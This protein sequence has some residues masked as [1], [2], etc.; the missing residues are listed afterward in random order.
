MSSLNPS[1][2]QNSQDESDITAIA[3]SPSGSRLAFF[4][5]ASS[6]LIHVVPEGTIDD[7]EPINEIKRISRA[8]DA[9]VHVAT[10]DSSSNFL[11]SGSA[12][13]VVKVW[14]VQRGYAT[15]LFKSHGGVISVLTF[16]HH[17][18]TTSLD[19]DLHLITGCVDCRIRLF[20]LTNESSRSSTSKP[21]AVLEGHTSVPKS[22]DI[23]SDGKWLIT[24]GRDG[25]AHLWNYPSSSSESKSI[26][27]APMK[28]IPLFERVEALAI[29]SSTNSAHSSEPNIQFYTGGEKGIVSVWDSKRAKWS[30]DLGQS[31]STKVKLS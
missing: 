17:K 18:A 20:R 13:G 12:D 1:C 26:T 5:S 6:L 19:F 3:V 7:K 28:T 25:V 24:G 30:N 11:A 10:F 14:D 21:V 2:S 15:H 9:P 8:H 4:T 23:S 27:Q 22:I 29:I 16:H 31:F